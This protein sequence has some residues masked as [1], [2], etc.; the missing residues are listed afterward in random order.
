MYI[1]ETQKGIKDKGGFQLQHYCLWFDD[2]L[3]DD[4]ISKRRGVG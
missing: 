2:A 3:S 4:A 1:Y